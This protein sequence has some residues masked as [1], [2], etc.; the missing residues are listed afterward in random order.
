VPIHADEAAVGDGDAV[1]I[2]G[3]G[4]INPKGLGAIE[5]GGG[6]EDL[7]CPPRRHQHGWEG[8]GFGE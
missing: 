8:V 3:E 7:V 4:E 2:A 6:V 5:R 1:G